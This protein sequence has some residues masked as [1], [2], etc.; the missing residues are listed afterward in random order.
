VLRWARKNAEGP[1]VRV[2]AP[3]IIDAC[4]IIC[5]HGLRRGLSATFHLSLFTFYLLPTPGS[6]AFPP[7]PVSKT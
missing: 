6:F 1:C 2:A 4:E 3:V 7:L 5:G